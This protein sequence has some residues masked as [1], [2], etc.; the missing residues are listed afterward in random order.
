MAN[1]PLSVPFQF[2]RT[3][4]VPLDYTS[5]VNSTTELNNLSA[6]ATSYLGMQ[7]FN[8]EDQT[9]YVLITSSTNSDPHFYALGGNNSS[10][11][12]QASTQLETVSSDLADQIANA[13]T[14]AFNNLTSLSSDVYG[15]VG[16]AL[17]QQ[18]SALSAFDTITELAAAVDSL[19]SYK[20]SSNFLSAS[21]PEITTGDLT[22]ANGYGIKMYGGSQSVIDSDRNV[23]ANA[24]YVGADS[25]VYPKITIDG[26]YAAA[27]YYIKTDG[28][29]KV[30]ALTAASLDLG[31]SG[32]I[33]NAGAIGAQTVTATGEI[34]GLSLSAS[35][36]VSGN[37]LSVATS[38]TAGAGNF[39]V[40]N[41]GAITK[42]AGITSQGNIN[43]QSYNISTTGTVEATTLSASGSVRGND[44]SL[45][46]GITSSSENFKVDASGNVT[47][48]SLTING[49]TYKIESTGDAKLKGLT[50]DSINNNGA[51]SAASG[52]F[53]VDSTGNVTVGESEASPSNLTVTGN[54]SVLG[55]I[56][57]LDTKV[58]TMSAISAVLNSDSATTLQV[59]QLGSFPIATFGNSTGTKVQINSTGSLSATQAAT[60]DSTVNVGGKLTVNADISSSQTV[61]ASAAQ[62]SSILE[63]GSQGDA[64]VLYV[65]A[66]GVGINT[67]TLD[68][69]S[70][71]VSG[72]SDS[73]NGTLYVAGSAA[74]GSYA[75][76]ESTGGEVATSGSG[77]TKTI[78]LT[79]NKRAVN[80]ETMWTYISA[81]DGGSF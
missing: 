56:T 39:I 10:A 36:R 74:F 73:G 29:A 13:Q 34:K 9:L 49:G 61:Y 27:E 1:I 77:S 5:V 79:G 66:S 12:Q 68:G 43:A 26:V 57:Y 31:G 30:G 16:E 60:F 32:A 63:V 11:G 2:R 81:L 70:L 3:S 76:F 15:A 45:T 52:K 7:V 59:Q 54:L 64:T 6:A 18:I 38:L 20:T 75:T 48:A 58:T 8:V 33:T 51:L 55:D 37:E 46:Q 42:V 67:E 21:N 47:A 53:V 4:N 22:L 80:W 71:K 19:S 41:T 14:T 72:D 35:D 50:V 65:N 62:F 25:N 69:Y 78:S 23:F 40:D 17:A 24:L 28:V 44:L